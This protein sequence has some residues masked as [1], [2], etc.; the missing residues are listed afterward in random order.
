MKRRDPIPERPLTPKQREALIDIMWGNAKVTPFYYKNFFNVSVDRRNIT[1]LVKI[2]CR[3]GC[4]RI[5]WVDGRARGVRA[6]EKGVD[7]L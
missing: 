7:A 6:T 3:K 5:V 1:W 2:L 4:A